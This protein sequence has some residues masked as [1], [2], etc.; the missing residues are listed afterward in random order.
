[1]E[2]KENNI[3]LKLGKFTVKTSTLSHAS[4]IGIASLEMVIN[5]LHLGN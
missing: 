3:A 2:Y 5:Q 4:S 1:L